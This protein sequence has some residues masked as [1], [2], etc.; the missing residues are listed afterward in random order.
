[1]LI[2]QMPKA[3]TVEE[4][5]KEAEEAAEALTARLQSLSDAHWGPNEPKIRATS[6][7]LFRLAQIQSQIQIPIKEIETTKKNTL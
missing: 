5:L 6:E 1:M 4:L 3:L 2:R 7:T